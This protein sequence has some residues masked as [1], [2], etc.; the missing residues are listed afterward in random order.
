MKSDSSDQSMKTQ[1]SIHSPQWVS[2]NLFLENN[3]K[4]GRALWNK[5]DNNSTEHIDNFLHMSLVKKNFTKEL[6]F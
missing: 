3:H 4:Y 5:K 6:Y 2:V 1:E